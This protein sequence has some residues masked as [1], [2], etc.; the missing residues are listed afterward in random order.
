MVPGLLGHAELTWTFCRFWGR[1]DVRPILELPKAG[2]LLL[3]SDE[4]DMMLA[5]APH[6][7]WPLG[8]FCHA[9]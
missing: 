2:L 1:R 8:H 3:L 5:L 6:C 7:L 4:L 9:E